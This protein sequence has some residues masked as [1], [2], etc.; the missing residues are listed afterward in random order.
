MGGLFLIATP[1]WAV[2]LLLAGSGF[3]DWWQEYKFRRKSIKVKGKVVGKL[4]A[5]HK[6]LQLQGNAHDTS[7]L[8]TQQV[9][10]DKGSF[11]YVEFETQ[12]GKT[13]RVRSKNVYKN[14]K[15]TEI[16]V[17][18]NPDDPTD[19]MINSY[20]ITGSRKYYLMAFG[21]FLI[22][23][24]SII[25]AIFYMKMNSYRSLLMIL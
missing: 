10:L 7:I 19:V 16:D 6:T 13:Y 22:I 18:Y 3:S 17:N 5:V 1:F 15:N 11:L 2:G 12:E 24:P 8:F 23:V 9:T 14:F 20:Y 21:L 25:V 4:P